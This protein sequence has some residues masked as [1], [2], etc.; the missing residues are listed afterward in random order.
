MSAPPVR[1]SKVSFEEFKLFYESTEKVTDRRLAANNWN[2]A[3]CFATIVAVA[4]ISDWGLRRPTFLI[5]AISAV[6]LL[7]VMAMLFCSLWIGQIRDFKALNN[8]KFDVLNE[9][10]PRVCFSESGSDPRMSF[11]PFAR[12]WEKL[13]DARALTEVHRIDLIALK[14]SNIEYLIPR[15]FRV[16]FGAVLLAVGLVCVL[17]W[18]LVVSTAQFSVRADSMSRTTP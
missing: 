13:K 3:I 16:L 11:E 17:N 14:A 2:Y 4:A 1:N 9:M 10:A 5:V 12:E 6:V 18:K 15:A 8:A 7:C